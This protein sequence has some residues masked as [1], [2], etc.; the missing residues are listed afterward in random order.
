M[1]PIIPIVSNGARSEVLAHILRQRDA[2][3]SFS[4][5]D[6]GGTVVGWSGSV[7][8]AIV[9]IN[10]PSD[11]SESGVRFFKVNISREE[12][13]TVVED[14]VAEHGTFDFSICTHTLEDI[15]NPQLVSRKLS[16]ISKGGYVAVPSKF[17]ELSRFERVMGHGVSYRG[18]IHHRWIYTVRN[19]VFLGFPKVSFVEVDPFFDA[20]AAKVT[21]SNIDLSFVWR[22]PLNLQIVNG[23]YL[24]PSIDAVIG[25]Y[26]DQ[27]VD[28]DVDLVAGAAY[29]AAL[30]A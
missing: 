2:D 6:V 21:A 17:V 7:A 3:P 23:D 27:L 5:I 25:Y 19:G 24:G 1:P 4:V 26:H 12:D 20:I 13:W 16:A 29:Q 18:H 11:V 14:Y 30:S 15:A 8:N 22:A 9:D 10:P 28:D